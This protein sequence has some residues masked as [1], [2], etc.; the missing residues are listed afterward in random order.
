MGGKESLRTFR[1]PYSTD[2]IFA[3][4]APHSVGRSSSTLLTRASSTPATGNMSSTKIGSALA[5]FEAN[6]DKNR[7][8]GGV[9]DKSFLGNVSATPDF[10][11]H[12]PKTPARRES[13]GTSETY[14]SD[15]FAEDDEGVVRET[16]K[17]MKSLSLETS[18]SEHEEA[19]ERNHP[20]EA[21]KPK[22]SSILRK[23]KFVKRQASMDSD[24]MKVFNEND[25]IKVES[26]HSE[27]F[28]G[29][30]LRKKGS[31]GSR[32]SRLSR[33]GSGRSV[34]SVDSCDTFGSFMGDSVDTMGSFGT[35]DSGRL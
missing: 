22:A 28:R 8:H 29:R 25:Y 2:I 21:A 18:G 12:A 31:M 32:S 3:G 30:G 4:S 14:L 23:P 20:I 7:A 6:I 17:H 16:T 19:Q 27:V 5:V 10:K 1:P 13:E 9:Q 26:T 15:G 33:R 35:C 34:A 24:E 11:N